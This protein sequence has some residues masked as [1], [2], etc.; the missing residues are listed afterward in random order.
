ME[1]ETAPMNVEGVRPYPPM[2]GFVPQTRLP[3][4]AGRNDERQP[5]RGPANPSDVEHTLTGGATFANRTTG[6]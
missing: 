6:R 3:T 1:D 2:D 5:T 4:S